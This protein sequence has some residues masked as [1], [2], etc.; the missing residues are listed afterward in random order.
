MEAA[1]HTPGG[2]DGV[3]QSVGEEFVKADAEE[4]PLRHELD[5]AKAIA[6]GQLSSPFRY[7]NVW[8]F[9]IRITG[10]G[11]A[12]RDA[13]DEHVYRPPENYLSDDFLQRCNGLAVVFEHPEADPE[14][15]KKPLLDAQEYKDRSIGSILYPYVKGDEVWGVAKIYDDDAAL[16]MQTTHFSTSPGVN[17][18]KRGGI[19]KVSLDNDE[20][21]MVEGTPSL[22]D[23]IAVCQLGVWDKGGAPSG[24][25]IGDQNMADEKDV[26]PEIEAKADEAPAWAKAIADSVAGLTARMDSIDKARA[27]AEKPDEKVKEE[28][29]AAK[30]KADADDKEKAEKESAYADMQ[31]QIGELKRQLPRDLTDE[32]RNEIAAAQSRADSVFAAIGK[33]VPAAMMGETA[34]AYRRRLAGAIQQMSPKWKTADLKNLPGDVFA[35]IEDAIYTDA[36]TAARTPVGVPANQLRAI[37]TTSAAGHRI[38]TYVGSPRAW[39]EQFMPPVKHVANFP[40]KE[41]N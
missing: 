25:N 29:E 16:A 23:H 34:T 11:Y 20:I 21:I 12:H 27:D 17:F 40:R 38:T 32:E 9:D 5:H 37:N 26:K 39:M 15:G 2:Y 31:R 4:L 13:L 36:Q 24:V 19:Q 6:A 41:A 30:A 18:G 14:T 3:P 35:N 8:L 28:A 22:L 33:T 7:E 1:A 10:T